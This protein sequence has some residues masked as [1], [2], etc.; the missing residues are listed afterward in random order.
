MVLE[1]G[2]ALRLPVILAAIILLVL[3]RGSLKIPFRADGWYIPLYV[4]S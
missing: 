2:G 1:E 4:Q 3:F